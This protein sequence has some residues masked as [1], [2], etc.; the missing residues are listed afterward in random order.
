MSFPIPYS[1]TILIFKNSKFTITLMVIR[2]GAVFM[3]EGNEP[4]RFV[5]KEAQPIVLN[6][7]APKN[8]KN[9]GHQRH[10]GHQHQLPFLV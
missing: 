4:D 3:E 7:V 6:M 10:Q 1:G 5:L 2:I 9:K 8:Y